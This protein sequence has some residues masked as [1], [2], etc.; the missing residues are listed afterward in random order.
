M[1]EKKKLDIIQDAVENI[2]CFSIQSKYEVDC[3]RKSCPHWI[4]HQNSRNC[5]IVAAGAGPRTLQSVGE[6]FGLTRM[7]I[8]QIEKLA[9]RKIKGTG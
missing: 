5:A 2:T 1:Q 4:E 6:I 7:R 3:Q 8:C 9:N